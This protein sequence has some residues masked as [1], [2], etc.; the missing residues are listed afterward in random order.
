MVAAG[1]IETVTALGLRCGDRSHGAARHVSQANGFVGNCVVQGKV[2]VVLGELCLGAEQFFDAHCHRA[3]AAGA[4]PLANDLHDIF[5][6]LLD[7][8]RQLP[9]DLCAFELDRA[10]LED[11]CE[12]A[13]GLSARLDDLETELGVQQDEQNAMSQLGFSVGEDNE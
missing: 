9:E 8:S 1:C 7:G 2:C 11:L 5:V 13:F 3:L 10:H 6:G 4:L 12:L